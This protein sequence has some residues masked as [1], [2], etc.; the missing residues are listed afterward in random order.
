MFRRSLLLTLVI[1]VGLAAGCAKVEEGPDPA[2]VAYDALKSAWNEAE[3][4]EAKVALAADYLARY[5]DT[6][7]SGRMASAIVYY[8][9][10]EM[11]DPQG[12]WDIVSVAMAQIEDPEQRFTAG[13]EALGLA[14]S[15]DVPLDI[16]TL[17]IDLGAV[18]PLTFDE[19]EQVAEMALEL[20]E[21]TIADE[22][23]LGALEMATPE[24]LRT[25]YPDR[26]FTDQ[27][28]AVR[29]QRRKASA[30]TFDG[31]A[32]YNLGD[33]EL[34]MN[35][36]AAA[37]EIGSVSYLGV[38]NT[39]LNQY[40]GRAALS[41]GDLDR[42]IELLSVEVL[43]GED[44]T[45]AKPYLLEAYVAKN[46]SEEGFDEFLWSTRDRVARIADDFELLDY[47]GNSRSLS[48]TN[49]KVTLLAFWFPT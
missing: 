11:K 18:R 28:V 8:Q 26:E 29:V 17:A 31:W 4:P 39:P 5:P 9:G 40:W 16:A 44:P 2:E 14:D 22:H 41:E 30:L 33:T 38:P 36:F 20:E 15:V 6:K 7:H 45:A 37:D 49:G 19:H 34:A 21:W 10:H 23:S 35:R 12:A 42:A 1:L 3:T 13:L 43:F 24:Q 47:E 25:D 46:G 32:L 27:E 48:E